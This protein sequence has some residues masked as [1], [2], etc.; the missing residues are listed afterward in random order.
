MKKLSHYFQSYKIQAVSK[1]DPMKCLYE[2]PSLVGRLA[3][4]LILLIEFDVQYLTKKTIKGRAVAE[5]LAINPISD[6]EEIQLDFPDDLSMAI[7]M[8]GWRMYFDGAVNQFRAGIEIILLTPEGEVVPIAKKLAFRVINNEAEYEA[9]IL[10]MEA[11]IAMGVI[12]VDIFG[13]S[14]LVINQAIEEWELKEQHLKPY[15]NHLQNLTLSFQ[16]CK[17]THLPRNHNQ[18]ADALASLASVWEGPSKMPMK[19]LILLKSNLLSHKCLSITKIKAQ[20]SPGSSISNNTSQKESTT[21]KQ[22]KKTK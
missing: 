1:M 17:F 14:M 9:C 21:E 6:S 5:F 8:Q 10:G 20:T 22:S 2:A 11:L 12:E 3:K 7:E 19:P 18:M 16:K 15:L 4:W 13:D